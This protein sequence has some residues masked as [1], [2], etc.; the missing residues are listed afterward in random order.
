MGTSPK[1]TKSRTTSRTK[2]SW[3]W[4]ECIKNND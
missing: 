4:Y 3:F 2:C 1:K